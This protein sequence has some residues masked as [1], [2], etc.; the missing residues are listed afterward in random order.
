MIAK[1]PICLNLP[2]GQK[3]VV[4]QATEAV[5]KEHR[6]S[7]R[8]KRLRCRKVEPLPG[9][10]G[11]TIF[12]LEIGQSLEFDWTWEGAIAFRPTD[13]ETFTGNDAGAPNDSVDAVWTGEIVE[14]DETNGRLFVS[15][16]DLEQPPCIGSFFVRPFEFLAFLQNLFCHPSTAKLRSLLNPRLGASQGEIHPT[17]TGSSVFGLKELEELWRHSWAI[18]WGPPGTGKTHTLGRQIAACLSDPTERILVVSTTNRATDA[19]ALAIGRAALTK[20]AGLIGQEKVLRIGK[21]ADWSAYQ[22]NS[23]SALLRGTETEL[24]KEIGELNRLLER[25]LTPEERAPLRHQ[26]HEL[27]R[28]MK[29]S[30]SNI[31]LSENVQ[32]VVGTAFKALTLLNTPAVT[33]MIAS[34]E[35]PFT[36]VVIDEAGLMSRAAVSVLS[37]LAARRVVVVG[38]A[39]QLAPISKVSRILPQSEADWL[40]SS[41]LNHLQSVQQVEPGVHLLQE[42]YRMHPDISRAVSQF[43]YDG[44]LRDAPN[45]LNRQSSLPPILDG[46]PRAI[47]Y[48]LDEDCEDIPS[49]RAERGPGNRSWVRS[50][51]RI[52]LQK[53]FSDPEIRQ[54]KG[55]FITPFK[56]QAKSIASYF[57]EERMQSWSA[58][59][60]HAQQGTEANI[61]IFDTVNAG[62]CG[63]Q[64]EEWKRLVNVGLSRAR[65]FV[66]FLASRAEMSEPY[67]RPLLE[68]LSPRILKKTNRSVVWTEVPAKLTFSAPPEIAGNP[69]LLGNQLA[70]RKLLRPL[71]TAEQ[72]WLCSLKMDGKP[73]LVRGV[74]GS[75]KTVVLAH[76]LCKTVQEFSTIPN[77][78][79]WAVYANK[80]LKRLIADMVEEAWKTIQPGTQFPW[81]RVSFLHAN[82]IMSSLLLE[83]G[84]FAGG[85]N[86]D[87]MAETYLKHKPV[88]QVKPRC[89]A[90]FI[91]EAQDMGPSLLKLLSA[92]IEPTDTENLKAR[93]ANI[94]YD[95]AQ[96]IYRRKTPKWSDL[97]LDMRGRSTVMKESFRSTKPITEFALNVLYRLQ[98]PEAD[99][100]HKELVERSLIERTQKNGNHWWNVRFNQVN[101][102]KPIYRK[103]TTLNNQIEGVVEEVIR[104]IQVDG[105][106]PSDICIL[107]NDKSFRNQIQAELAPRLQAIKADIATAPGQ[108]DNFVV[109]MTSHSFKGYEAEIVII[110]GAE[111]FIAKIDGEKQILANNLYVAMT[112]AR[113]LLAVFAYDKKKPDEKTS[114]LLMTVE[115]CLDCLLESPEVETEISNIEEFEDVLETLGSQH[116][117]WLGNLWKRHQIQRER[118][119][120][121]N[122]E[123]LGEPLFW[124]T[125]EGRKYACFGKDKPANRTRFKLEDDGFEIIEPGQELMLD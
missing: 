83:I 13:W 5:R 24:L 103:F 61:V 65:E 17:V 1:F 28:Q 36:T 31:F 19:A 56:A 57:A 78:K 89:Q 69:N 118:I 23:L 7:I 44:A 35:S 93:A 71:M 86:Y 101:G 116:R 59:T 123:I 95:N 33:A 20:W 54:A 125:S 10:S 67:L 98:P 100:D 41:C 85:F 8:W 11:N 14:V 70:Q 82:E 6:S 99:Q 43:Q 96:N 80:T 121:A 46:Q 122:G 68:T 55:L 18:L 64:T 22:A 73:R 119:V 66:L 34:G 87:L 91:D 109:A 112:R 79:I 37:L 97:G 102:P 108:G 58:G 105:V 115:Q 106:R 124:F 26:I 52:I 49:I 104:W 88:E 50:G 48:V 29:D 16:S 120:A 62:S 47:W 21:G 51:T 117:A 30:A 42:Q 32:V 113:S 84:Q 15:V 72:Q 75:G 25:A 94:F 2:S 27:R 110:A 60:V 12:V 53:L 114:H 111:R 45:V 77:A 38:D 3:Q 63:W 39:K 107:C 90:M 76:W 9:H 81:N 4:D 40:A 74:A 92:L